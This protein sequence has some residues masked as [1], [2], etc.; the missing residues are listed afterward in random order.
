MNDMVIELLKK[1]HDL[2]AE[3]EKNI[4][5]KRQNF[6]YT[7]K[8]NKIKFEAAII[9]AHRELRTGVFRF[10][11]DTDFLGLL[12]SPVIY[13]QIVPLALL[14]IAVSLYQFIIFPIY[15]ITKVPRDDFIAVDRHHLSYLNVIEKLNC[16]FCG[17]A[18]GVLSYAREIA[19]RSE[20]HW[21]PIKHA[22][23]IKGRDRRYFGF[24][25]YG[26]ADEFRK[27]NK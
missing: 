1:I 18:N 5:E 6:H 10:I 23:K 17:Y 26:D 25:E 20:E 21:C 12:F 22:R 8:E 3:V 15:G 7:I 14:D 9:Q 4:E 2:E 11:K 24:A 16:A 13:I 27:T 19:G